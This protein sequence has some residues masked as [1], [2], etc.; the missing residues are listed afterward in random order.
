MIIL[1]EKYSDKFGD[2]ERDSVNKWK[3]ASE[4]NEESHIEPH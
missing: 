1:E 2:E 4:G 3:E